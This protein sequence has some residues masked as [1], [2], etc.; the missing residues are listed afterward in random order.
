[1]SS[2]TLQKGMSDARGWS[3]EQDETGRWSTRKSLLFM[4]TASIVFWAALT[5]LLVR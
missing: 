5:L 1:M 3:D 2:V 4:A